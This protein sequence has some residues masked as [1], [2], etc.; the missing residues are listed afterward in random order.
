MRN[1][2]GSY[3]LSLDETCAGSAGWIHAKA[4]QVPVCL[5]NFKLETLSPKLQ[6]C[7]PAREELAV[8]SLNPKLHNQDSAP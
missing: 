3:M 2:S 8:G 7:G 6:A 4:F 1:F 5:I